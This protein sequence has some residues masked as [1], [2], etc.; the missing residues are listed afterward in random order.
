MRKLYQSTWDHEIL[1]PERSN[2]ELLLIRTLL[3]E[4]KKS[5][6]GGLLKLKIRILFYGYNS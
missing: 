2:D 5:E 1:C 6:Y 3:L 4:T